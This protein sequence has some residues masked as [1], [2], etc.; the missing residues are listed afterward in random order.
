M[1]TLISTLLVVLSLYWLYQTYMNTNSLLYRLKKLEEHF[2][3][4][5]DKIIELLKKR[6]K[7]RR[8]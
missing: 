2:Q 6:R 7:K 4:Q 3:I 1:L 5:Q 8:H